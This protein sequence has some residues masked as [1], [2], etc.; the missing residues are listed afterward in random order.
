MPQ[1]SNS[2]GG[3]LD[4]LWFDSCQIINKLH[5]FV[6]SKQIKQNLICYPT[7]SCKN[8]QFLLTRVTNARGHINF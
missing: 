4:D 6:F 2:F 1:A 3:S 5:V 7:F 8:I